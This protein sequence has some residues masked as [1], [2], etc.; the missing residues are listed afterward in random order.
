VWDQVTY[1]G[2]TGYVADAFINTGQL[3][4]A[5]PGC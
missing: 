2:V 5:V 3:T 1:N 4:P